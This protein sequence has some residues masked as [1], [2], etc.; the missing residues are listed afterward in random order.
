MENEERSD[1]ELYIPVPI[2]DADDY[3]TGIGKKEVV[4]ILLASSVAVIIGILL[5]VYKGT[6]QG[7]I[8][9]V[10]II[11]LTIMV[12]RRDFSNENLLKKLS[13]YY[14]FC[15]APKRYIYVFKNMYDCE[16]PDED[17]DEE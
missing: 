12:I 13:I 7:V 10:T 15:K 11:T 2:P 16:I 9:G 4:I 3:I 8:T 5:S 17:E 6:V 14:K 1:K